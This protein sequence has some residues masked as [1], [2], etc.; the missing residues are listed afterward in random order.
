MTFA[1]DPVEYVLV[2]TA[3][4]LEEEEEASKGRIIVCSLAT[5]TGAMCAG[6]RCLRSLMY[7]CAVCPDASGSVRSRLNVANAAACRGAAMA[8][9]NLSGRLVAGINAKVQVFR[10]D[11]HGPTA[12]ATSEFRELVGTW[13]ARPKPARCARTWH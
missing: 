11:Y 6:A 1:D 10:W 2:G 13:Q 12:D 5:E 7:A 9:A 4:V 8:L 3:T